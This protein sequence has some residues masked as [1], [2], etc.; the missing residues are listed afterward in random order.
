MNNPYIPAKHDSPTR[1]SRRAAHT[2]P[3][4]ELFR[5]GSADPATRCSVWHRVFQ[6]SCLEN[7]RQLCCLPRPR[8]TSCVAALPGKPRQDAS[9]TRCP[10]GDDRKLCLRRTCTQSRTDSEAREVLP[11]FE[12]DYLVGPSAG[13]RSLAHTKV[14]QVP[15]RRC[16]F[17]DRI[18]KRSVD[19]CQRHRCGRLAAQNDEPHLTKRTIQ[20]TIITCLPLLKKPTTK[21]SFTTADQEALKRAQFSAL[22]RLHV[23]AR[24]NWCLPR[25]HFSS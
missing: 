11:P 13:Q 1:P 14:A 6:Q 18:R 3:A 15:D 24:T 19:I 12:F 2:R 23:C 5:S 7:A 25:E 8:S 4:P 20:V 16:S 17:A 10:V 22:V 21:P 9:L